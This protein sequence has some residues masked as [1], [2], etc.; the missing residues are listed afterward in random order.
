MLPTTNHLNQCSLAAF[1]GLLPPPHDKH[2]MS[3][4]FIFSEWHGLAKLR[5]HTDHTLN[6]LDALTTDLGDAIRGFVDKTCSKFDTKEL[7]RE[8]QARKRREARQRGKKKA[9]KKTG[10]QATN[11][12]A[13]EQ[14]PEQPRK[15]RNV[16]GDTPQASQASL[17]NEGSD[18]TYRK[19]DL[20]LI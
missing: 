12:E 3:L 15:R 13:H 18:K 8:Y 10:K 11:E 14:N 20:V 2:L 5:L 6:L 9:S 16:G 1:E 17:G 4:L 19:A 7:V